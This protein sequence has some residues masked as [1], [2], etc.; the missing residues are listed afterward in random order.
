MRTTQLTKINEPHLMALMVCELFNI[1]S[2]SCRIPRGT[3]ILL[4][5]KCSYGVVLYSTECG[6]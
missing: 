6:R 1:E 3:V 4:Y 2:L 5:M